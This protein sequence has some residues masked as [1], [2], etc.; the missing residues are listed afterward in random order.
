MNTIGN[1]GTC[2]PP[3][4]LNFK[5]FGPTKATEK[6]A[7][8]KCYAWLRVSSQSRD[9]MQVAPNSSTSPD[10]PCLWESLLRVS[11]YYITSDLVF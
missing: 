9:A 5:F 10:T 2:P 11:V 3:C 7:Y 1:V 4:S 6:A 8:D